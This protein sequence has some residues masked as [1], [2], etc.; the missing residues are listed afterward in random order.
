[1]YVLHWVFDPLPWNQVKGS[2]ASNKHMPRSPAASS[3]GSCPGSRTFKDYDIDMLNI[4][5]VTG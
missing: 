2:S 1:M 3:V 4:S 5:D